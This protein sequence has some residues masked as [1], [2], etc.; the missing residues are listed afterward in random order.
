MP[1][2]AHSTSNG[3][4]R[5]DGVRPRARPAAHVA[6]SASDATAVADAGQPTLHA[7]LN[8]A[9]TVQAV[10]QLKRI[11]NRAGSVEQTVPLSL[12]PTGR[13][14]NGGVVQRLK[15][16]GTDWTRVQSITSS[17][18]GAGGV[19][20][21]SDG[22]DKKLVVKPGVPGDEEMAAAHAHGAVS[23]IGGNFGKW[24]IKALSS[25]M[26]TGYDVGGIRIARQR[27]ERAPGAPLDART[28]GLVDAV[29]AGTTLIQEAAASGSGSMA[30]QMVEQSPAKHILAGDQRT[31][32]DKDKV[33]SDSPL[34]PL[35][36]ND[37]NFVRSLGR[38]A[39]TDL[40]LGNFDRIVDAANLEN[41]LLN[42]GKK[43][44]HPIDNT[45]GTAVGR[46]LTGGGGPVVSAAW[47]G[48]R[49]GAMF[50]AKNYA[51]IAAEVWTIGGGGAA[52]RSFA[53]ELLT[54]FLGPVGARTYN[55]DAAERAKA[56]TKLQNHLVHIQAAFAEGLQSGRDELVRAGAIPPASGVNQAARDQYVARL[57]VI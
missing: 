3:G 53:D 6:S 55:V 14:V 12:T 5:A 18:A 21:F 7:A 42:T 57:A 8:Q 56:Q 31:G 35:M 29:A 54:G 32:S 27:V 49:L 24:K 41:L 45:G 10:A 28:G 2:Y 26:A 44:M 46:L 19:L 36:K 25:R 40:L 51:G 30:D 39:A 16:Q 38:L 33:K 23:N 1:E 37:T 11:L 22:R 17:A 20:F 48:Q 52:M 4:N 15:V 43:A 50:I 34:K 47:Q 13:R 9:R